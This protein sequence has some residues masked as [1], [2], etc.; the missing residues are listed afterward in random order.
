MNMATVVITGANRGL[1]LALAQH[2]AASGATVVGGCRNPASAADLAATGAEVHSLDT[3]SSDSIAAFS[4]AVGDR[5]VDVLF[6]NAG[7]DARAVG[8][9]EAARGALD[10]TADEFQ[11]VMNVNVLGPLLMV[12]GL[13][14]NL[15]AAGGKVVNISSQVGSIEVAKRIGQDA[16]YTTSKA[17]LNMLTLKQ[18]QVMSPDG[19]AVIAMHPGWIRSEMGGPKADLE[20]AEAAAAIV[21]VVSHVG[22]EQTGSFLRWDGTVHPW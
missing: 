14:S 7:I 17:A 11:A 20:P 13:A 16:S 18:S 3:S 19:V 15:R 6:N 21:N 9:T 5:P 12:Q 4:A 10:L 22:L 8:A 1:G 2:Y